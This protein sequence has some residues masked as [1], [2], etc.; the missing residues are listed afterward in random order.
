MTVKVA[1]TVQAV[2]LRS[3]EERKGGTGRRERE[4][5]EKAGYDDTLRPTKANPICR[6]IGGD[7]QVTGKPELVRQ[8]GRTSQMTCNSRFNMEQQ[9]QGYYFCAG[10]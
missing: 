9:C 1:I 4:A 6:A 5:A 2:V 8:V 3:E 7:V 10:S